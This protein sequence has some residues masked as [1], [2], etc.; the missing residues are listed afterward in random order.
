MAMSRQGWGKFRIAWIV[1][2]AGSIAG[3][4]IERSLAPNA[5]PD[6]SGALPGHHFPVLSLAF[7]PENTT[8]TSAAG[9]PTNPR[10]EVEL[11]V[12]DL[13]K[14]TPLHN[15]TGFQSC[16]ASLALA[17]DASLLATASSS[18]RLRWWE[19][20]VS[21]ESDAALDGATP[22]TSL[23]ISP[24]GDFLAS[25]NRKNE[26][27]LCERSGRRLWTVPAGHDRFAQALAFSPDHRFLVSGG[28]DG[29]VRLFETPSG[30]CVRTMAG[31]STPVLAMAYTP[32]GRLLA[33]GDRTGAV[34]IWEMPAGNEVGTLSPADDARPGAGFPNEVCALGFSPS[35]R[36]LA[37]AKSS[38][39]QLWNATSW[40]LASELTGH[41]GKVQCLAFSHDGT[42]LA[43]GSQSGMIRLWDL[44]IHL[45]MTP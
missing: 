41:A 2:V 20:G 14:R 18:G 37:V 31:H 27:T 3:V 5:A 1:L 26:L 44:A 8:L 32:D 6:R 29:T 17:P 34:K 10:E 15:K 35:G 30:Q 11:V 9:F 4:V 43:T 28:T 36:N 39:V 38:L 24:G 21:R 19:I 33:S 13:A 42:L 23:A 45:G 16:L 40:I 22:L 12:W 7:D 25:A